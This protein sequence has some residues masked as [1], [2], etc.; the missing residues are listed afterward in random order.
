MNPTNCRSWFGC[1]FAD[2]SVRATRFQERLQLFVELACG[3][4]DENSAGDATFSV[5]YAFHDAGGLAALRAVGALGGVHDL[6]AVSS[7]GDLGHYFSRILSV[8]LF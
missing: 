2:K 1:D 7:L 8:N 3:A 6:L 5:F 4:G